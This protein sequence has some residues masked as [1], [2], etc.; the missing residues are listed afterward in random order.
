MVAYFG[1]SGWAA[2]N[3]T[4]RGLLPRRPE[5]G[6]RRGVSHGTRAVR[7]A[8]RAAMA[9][10]GWPDVPPGDQG[11]D[12]RLFPSSSSDVGPGA[13][14]TRH[15]G[16]ARRPPRLAE[17]P[18]GVGRPRGCLSYQVLKFCCRGYVLTASTRLGC[19]SVTE[20]I[21]DWPPARCMPARPDADTG[22]RAVPIY[23]TTSFVFEDTDRR[24]QPVRAAEVR[25]DLQPD[26][27]PDGGGVRGAAG[28]PGGRDRRGRHGQRAGRRV[29]HVRL[30]GRRRR[31]HRRGRRAVR[32]H[33]HPARRDAAP[34]RRGHHVRRRRRRRRL[35]R[36]DH[37][38]H[39]AGVHRGDRQPVRRDR[40]PRRARRRRPRRRRAAGR[41]RHAGHALPVPADR[42]RRRHRDPLGHQV[43][44]RPRHHA[45]RRG[46]RVGAV[47]LGQ[48]Q[49]PADDRAGA[50]LRRADVVG[51]LPG[52]RRSSPSCAPSSCATSAPRCRR[53][54]RSCCCRAWRRCRSGWR[55]TWRTPAWWPSGWPPTRG[56]PTCA[57]PGCP[58]HPHHER[59][60][61]YL[62][63]GPGAVFAFG[64]RGG[65][66]ARASGSSSRCSCAA[67][68]PTSATPARW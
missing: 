13:T 47:R 48:R 64:V 29:P 55:R 34:V 45:G 52:V 26:R 2:T 10:D 46:G 16:A 9:V 33:D 49:L 53:T 28:Q 56:C 6:T 50:V 41:R 5:R 19:T 18:A 4:R 15:R 27:Q 36:G 8:V 51:Q 66:E 21:S 54:A 59:A 63:L 40:R 61:R 62:P 11:G 43:P 39:Q 23:Q 25:A 68:W 35:R 22:A 37:P 58:I 60:A 44:R 1:Q 12:D 32:R 14:G 17:P 24:G 7:H 65:R 30:P 42:A 31:P 38:G 57:G 3:S 20:R 67:T